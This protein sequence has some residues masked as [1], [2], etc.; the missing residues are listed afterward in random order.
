MSFMIRFSSG[1]VCVPIPDARADALELPAM[2]ANN[3]DPHRTAYTVTIDANAPG[4]VTTGISAHDRAFTARALANDKVGAAGFRRPG[5][6]L[7]LRAKAGLVRERRGHTEA[8]L[9]LARLAGKKPASAICEMIVDGELVQGKTELAGGRM[10]RRDDCLA[11]GKKHGIRVCTI[12]DMVSYV[13]Q[14]DGKLVA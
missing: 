13:E 3:R 7:P 9:E 5:H 10:M 4:V 6:V 12:E 11:F 8:A 2:V 14:R 1:Y